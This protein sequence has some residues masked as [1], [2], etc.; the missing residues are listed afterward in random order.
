MLAGMLAVGAPRSP[1]VWEFHAH[2]EVWVLVGSLVASYVFAVRV[3]GPR[4]VPPGERAVSRRQIAYFVAAITMLWV[5]SDWPVHDVGE[6]YLYSGHMLQHMMLSYFMPPLVLLATP[7][8]LARA[9]LGDGRLWAVVRRLC[10]P[11]VA[12]VAFNAAVMITHIP[13]LVNAAVDPGRV[14]GLLHYGLHFLLVGTALL[15]WVPVCGPLPELRIGQGAV[16][17]YLFAQS[18]IPTV[19]AGWL[20]FAEGAVYKAYDFPSPRV[21]GLSVTYDQQ[22]A[23]AIMK[24]GGSVFLWTIVT[25]LFFKRFMR[26]DADD[27]GFAARRKAVAA[28]R[29]ADTGEGLTFD[30]VQQAFDASPAPE[31][32]AR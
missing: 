12:G 29:A 5:A 16:L 25:T 3:I 19:P 26:S 8:W 22:M 31:E 13:P 11:V 17:I 21:F 9:L 14:G 28:E 6:R 20:T 23:G 1:D 10:H 18:V 30:Q 2:P 32:P 27:Y 24:V 4:A 15:M 7:T